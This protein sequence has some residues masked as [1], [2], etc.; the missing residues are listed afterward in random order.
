MSKKQS[1]IVLVIVG[2]LMVTLALFIFPLNGEDSFP[3]GD[4]TKD[5]YW[6]SKS[7]S[8]GLDLEGGMYAEYSGRLADGSEPSESDIEGAIAN[9]EDL[10]YSKSYSEAT[11]T[12]LG[13]NQIRVEVPNIEDTSE[14][15]KLIGKSATLEF[16]D[17]SGNVLITGEEHLKDCYAAMSDAEYVIKLEFNDAGTKAFAEATEANL[18]KTISIYIDGE[19][20][21]SPT[22]N[23]VISD[24]NAIIQGN[25]TYETANSYAVRL[26]AGISSVKLTLLRSETISPSLGDEALTNAIIAAAIGVVLIMIFLVIVYRGLGLAASLALACY[27]ELLVLFL[28]I[29]PWVQ[30]TLTGIAGVILSIGMAVDANVIIF[31]QIKEERLLTNKLVPSAIKTGFSKTLVTIIDANVTTILGSIVMLIVGSS[32]IKSFALTLLIG[33]LLSLVSS[34]FITR[35]FVNCFLALNDESES[36]YGLKHTEVAENE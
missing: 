27:I 1:I 2:I 30:L 35:L 12:K 26:K 10:L 32:A 11:V 24:G 8:L 25:Y 4:S 13:A 29:V 3:I 31:E 34:I 9:L 21:M 36:F 23:S 19:E 6:I 18:N 22:V 5:F 33:I 14:L 7:V 20:V 28:A 15:M 17:E 16:K